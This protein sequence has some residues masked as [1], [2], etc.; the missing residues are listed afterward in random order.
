MDPPD[1]GSSAPAGSA[2]FERAVAGLRV[3]L[4]RFAVTLTPIDDAQDLV[5]DAL[6]RAWKMRDR[7]SPERGSWR[8]W[9]LAIVADQA[10]QRWRRRRIDSQVELR[11]VS[12]ENPHDRSAALIDVSRAVAN[13][14]PRQR[15]AIIL[16]VF[17][18][19]KTSE[20]AELMHCSQGTVKA[21]LHAARANLT[22]LL[23]ESYAIHQF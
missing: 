21:T 22:I 15:T 14:P 2:E 9:L 20:I 3:T 19:L 1:V 5:Q 16:S 10:R 8:S 17:V 12:V 4:L 11:L 7:F 13:L 18:D 23:G 6:A